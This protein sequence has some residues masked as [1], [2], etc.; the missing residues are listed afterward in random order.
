MRFLSDV[1]LLHRFS[2]KQKIMNYPMITWC[3]I[4]AVLLC[5]FIF[6]TVKYGCTKLRGRNIGHKATP[7]LEYGREKDLFYIPEDDEIPGMA[8]KKHTSEDL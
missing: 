8:D 6:R 3:I 7:F 1:L 5:A 4:A 2:K